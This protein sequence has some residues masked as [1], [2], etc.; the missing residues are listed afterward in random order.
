MCA[1]NAPARDATDSSR[2]LLLIREKNYMTVS[3]EKLPGIVVR[4][5][6]V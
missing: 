3:D 4:N 5:A 2:L 6:A 1:F